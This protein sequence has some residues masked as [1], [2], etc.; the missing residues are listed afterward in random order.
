MYEVLFIAAAVAFF[1]VGGRLPA[2]AKSSVELRTG[3]NACE[4]ITTSN[5]GIAEH[6]RPAS[7]EAKQTVRWGQDPRRRRITALHRAVPRCGQLPRENRLSQAQHRTRTCA[8]RAHRKAGEAPGGIGSS[9][10]RQRGR[11]D[12]RCAPCRSARNSRCEIH[13]CSEGANS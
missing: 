2:T 11:A 4:Q 12:R 3:F 13:G 6:P 1:L 5:C 9:D 7:R 10:E 8:P